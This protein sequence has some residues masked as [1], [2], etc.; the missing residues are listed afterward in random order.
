LF[1]SGQLDLFIIEG[2]NQL[3]QND[4]DVT[5]WTHFMIAYHDQAFYEGHDVIFDVIQEKM[6]PYFQKALAIEPDNETTLYHILNYVLDN[7]ATLAQIGSKFHITEGNKGLFIEYAKK[8]IAS[9]ICPD[10]GT[11][12]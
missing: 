12:I 8:L 4:Q 10:M 11:T 9:P 5:L 2:E 7:Q 3:R 6:I 1:Y